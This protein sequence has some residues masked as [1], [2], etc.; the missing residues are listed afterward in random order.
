MTTN[1]SLAKIENPTI[2][3]PVLANPQ[4]VIEV[5]QEN[6]AGMTI[7]F[8]RVKI[9]SGGGLAFELPGGEVAKEL[10]G[11]ILDHYPV[12]A[13]WS[14]KYSGSNNPPDCSALDG[15]HGEGN[16]GGLCSKCPLNQWGSAVDEA[17]NPGRGKACKNIRRVYILREG[18][19][20]PILLALPPTSLGA[21]TDYMK[22]LVSR[23]PTPFYGCVTKVTLEKDKNAG[24]IVYSKAVFSKV[25]D[26][27]PEEKIAIKKY[28]ETLKPIMRAVKIE[29]V[30]YT[31]EDNDQAYPAPAAATGTDDAE[32]F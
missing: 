14:N 29:A 15:E 3:L 5:M 4:E 25:A 20:F 8:D 10:V 28:A 27:P 9:P 21:F 26:L 18:E 12:N 16:P 30:D 24:G 19:T 2:N 32:P 31:I 23:K 7:Q 1:I 17:G 22:R 6:L 13:Y 11:V